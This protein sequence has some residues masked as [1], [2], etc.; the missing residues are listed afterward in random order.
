MRVFQFVF[1]IWGFFACRD[2]SVT[3]DMD[4]NDKMF[5]RRIEI[6][7]PFEYTEGLCRRKID[8]STLSVA[9]DSS[10]G[11]QF[12]VITAVLSILYAVF[13]IFV[14]AYLD[15]MYKSKP[16]FPMAVR[17]FYAKSIIRNLIEIPCLSGLCIDCRARFLLAVCHVRLQ[18][19]WKCHGE[20]F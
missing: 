16:E 19:R 20:D 14:Y 1:A 15:Q 9:A 6:E 13:I 2:F 11:A 3:I 4:C 10:T 7:Y 17:I 8:N 18:Q 5:Q 12:F